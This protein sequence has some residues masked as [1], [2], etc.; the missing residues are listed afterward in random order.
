VAT[1]SSEGIDHGLGWGLEDKVVL[2]TGGAQG[3][4]RAT[5]QAFAAAGS[6]VY[7]VDQNGDGVRATVSALQDPSR[8]HAR[9]FD[10]GD[11][12]GIAPLVEDCRQR[13]GPPWALANVA[14]TLVRQSID[15]V[16]EE[17]WDRQ[18]DVNL[19]S[20]FFLGR[21][22][23]QEMV[24][25][26]SG[27]RIINFSSAGFLRG[28]LQGAHSYVASKGGIIGL[29]R[30]F[31]RAYGPHGITVNTVMPGQIDTPMQHVDNTP[32]TIAATIAQSALKRMGQPEEVASVVVF[33][34]S[35]HA[36]F[37]TGATILVGGGAMMY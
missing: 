2:V 10:L 16:T 7:A 36:S 34:A 22:M 20:N 11:I 23:A 14:S 13:L 26:G 3:I 28:P 8:H 29:T 19:K 12:K 35:R 15:D 5:V 27:G 37:I 24:A 1:A 4:G 32:E 31:A 17:T 21:A 30:G 6:R 33:L 25:A 18:L 9:S